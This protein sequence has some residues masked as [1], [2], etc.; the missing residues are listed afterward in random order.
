MWKSLLK[1]LG[2]NLL[3]SISHHSKT[4]DQ[5]KCFNQKIKTELYLYVN[6]LQDNWVCWLLIIEFIDNNAIN[7]SIKMTP[8]YLNKGFSPCMSFSPDITKA[9]TVQK[10]LQIHSAIKIARIINRILLIACDNLI[11]AQSN[12]IRQVNH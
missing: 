3:I 10:K 11:K 4:D 5:I 12:M 6:H 2:I 9:G 7:K 1:Q 8:F